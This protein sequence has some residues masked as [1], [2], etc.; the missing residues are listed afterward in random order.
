MEN[1]YRR[2]RQLKTL[3]HVT[4]WSFGPVDWTGAVPARANQYKRETLLQILHGEDKQHRHF[5][6]KEST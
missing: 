5:Q 6:K 2:Q 3:P 1:E 4:S